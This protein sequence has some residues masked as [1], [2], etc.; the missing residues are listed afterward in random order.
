M[1]GPRVAVSAVLI[2]TLLLGLWVDQW[3]GETQNLPGLVL[4][5][6]LAVVGVG[7]SFE[8]AAMMQSK[9]AL[10]PTAVLGASGVLGLGAM[11]V[12]ALT[13]MPE[14]GRVSVLG[15]TVAAVFMGAL[16]FHCRRRQTQGAI[17]AGAG[18]VFACVYLGVFPGFWMLVRQEHAAWVVAGAL[19][20]TKSCDIGAYLT[21][22]L[23]GRNKL[24]P[25]LSPGKTWEGLAGG[26]VF[27]AALSAGLV[28]WGNATGG[29]SGD[30]QGS[31]RLA[32]V[33]FAAVAGLILGLVGQLGDLTA[34]LLKRDAG[35]K[36]S[37][38]S[39]PG[40]G[41]VLD[42]VDSAIVVA[43]VAYWLLLAAR[44]LP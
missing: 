9:G 1:L 21:G 22:R 37:G 19:L 3:L 43:P 38:A 13:P 8:V 26:L 36:D 23:I 11:T 42:L 31:T 2:P 44:W 24:I 34:S 28:A 41:G 25:W 15:T 12:A 20:V 5:V 33:W 18:A 30:G 4:F 17:L 29:L 6:M 32:P 35:I 27:A 7:A 16:L 39:V 14:F 40:F 10:T